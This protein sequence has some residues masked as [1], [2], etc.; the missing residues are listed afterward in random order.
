MPKMKN[1]WEVNQAN[2]ILDIKKLILTLESNLHLE[3]FPI[4]NI[5]KEVK[6]NKENLNLNS[7]LG[8]KHIRTN[9]SNQDKKIRHLL[10]KLTPI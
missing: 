5:Q 3:K 9:L 7:T 10:H 2:S 4:Q 8:T 1:K 6:N